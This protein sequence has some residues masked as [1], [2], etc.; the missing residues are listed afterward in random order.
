MPL[1]TSISQSSSSSVSDDS[2]ESDVIKKVRWALKEANDE[3]RKQIKE[4]VTLEEN[5]MPLV[6]VGSGSV[7]LLLWCTELFD[8]ERLRHWLVTER[9][10]EIHVALF[11]RLLGISHDIALLVHIEWRMEDYD[12]GVQ[13]FRTRPGNKC[14]NLN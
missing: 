14:C 10:Q 2:T 1:H 8:L 13:Y 3:E 6:E 4:L 11:R 7:K 12:R 9:M 5:G